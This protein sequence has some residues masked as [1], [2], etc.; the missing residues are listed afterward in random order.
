MQIR[1]A[2]ADDLDA[3]VDVA[4]IVDPPADDAEVDVSYYR[5]LLEHGRLV[6]ADASGIVIGYAAVIDVGRSRHVSDLF[7]HQDARGHGIGRRLLDA[8]WE[9]RA[10]VVPRQTFSSL[11]RAALPLYV[12]A[13]MAPMWPLLY[14]SGSS[15]ALPL[16]PLAVRELDAE[17][18]VAAEAEWLGWDRSA[19]YGYWSSR[20]DARTFAVRDGESTLAVG[21]T[22][23][24]RTL[25]TLS[26]LACVDGSVV[27]DAAAAAARW[28][29][30]DVM[31][32]A[33]G[34]SHAV[35]VL[36]N[37]GW[38]VVEHDVYCAS[39]P[40]LIDPERLLPHPGLL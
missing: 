11:H 30:D 25:H 35:P 32:A 12:R 23:R 16:S 2:A 27:A 34:V 20:P 24:N 22:V 29:G 8:V 5:H 28:C 26:R 21:C 4:S 39:E 14:L 40:G 19:E 1:I 17:S 6:V 7:V 36:I 37:A 31:V 18:A 3:V 13:G 15:A 10:A 38:R 33:P 9:T